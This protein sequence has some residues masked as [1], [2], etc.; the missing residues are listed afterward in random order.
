MYVRKLEDIKG[1]DRDINWGNGKSYRLLIESD[2]IGYSICHTVVK[3]RTVSLLQYQNHLEA[4][5]CIAGEGE[6]EDMSGNV[7]PIRPGDLYVLDQHDR[8][9]LRGG[10]NADLVLLSV[11]NPPLKGMERHDLTES[12][13]STY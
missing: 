13:A 3:A 9:Y 5:Y 1:T 10:R 8:H 6:V 12:G 4:C 2:G 11:F 7:F